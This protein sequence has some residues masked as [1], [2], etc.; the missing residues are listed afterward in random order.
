MIKKMF[1]PI[2]LIGIAG[3]ILIA[4]FLT[5]AASG[6]TV[7]KPSSN[8]FE[9]KRLNGFY[10]MYELLKGLNNKTVIDT[11]S[12]TNADNKSV[13]I[14]IDSSESDEFLTS[15]V[16]EWI[17]KGNNLV[18][19]GDTA[20][21][22]F[23]KDILKYGD[24]LDI[25]FLP[26]ELNDITEYKSQMYIES[27]YM[28]LFDEYEVIAQTNDGPVIIKGYLGSGSIT[29]ITSFSFFRNYMFDNNEISKGYIVDYLIR[30][31]SNEKIYLREKLGTLTTNPSFIRDFFT[32]SYSY[33]TIHISVLF[34]LLTLYLGKRFAKPQQLV[35]KKQ[36]RITEHIYAVGNLYKRADA[37]DLIRSIDIAFFKTVICKNKIP[38]NIK[39]IVYNNAI[40]D[41]GFKNGFIL[42][43]TLQKIIKE[44]KSDD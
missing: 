8:H 33:I 28:D 4:L 13:I 19:D 1:S 44:R 35:V 10:G 37:R 40:K 24:D 26:D 15:Q 23:K 6:I 5:S 14:Y 25:N 38:F 34:I 2:I 41:S 36:K 31:F 7:D 11:A 17:T 3:I 30:P 27:I 18:A 22:I 32:G 43:E 42:R 16:S 20:N 9:N 39:E 12:Y 21:I 29:L